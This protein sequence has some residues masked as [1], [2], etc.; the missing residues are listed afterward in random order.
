MPARHLLNFYRPDALPGAQAE[1]IYFDNKIYSLLTSA[2][3]T[4]INTRK[5]EF[6]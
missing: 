2:I 1:G 6:K 4:V 3:Y 5:V